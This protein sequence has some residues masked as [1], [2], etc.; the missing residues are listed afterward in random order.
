MVY[1]VGKLTFGPGFFLDCMHRHLV[2]AFDT[3]Y[4]QGALVVHV[5]YLPRDVA[6]FIV[7]IVHGRYEVG[8]GGCSFGN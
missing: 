8:V 2:L 3:V 4:C 7:G 6:E 5:Y 1:V